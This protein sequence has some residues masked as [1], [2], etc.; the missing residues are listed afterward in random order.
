MVCI[1]SNA[2]RCGV[3][4]FVWRCMWSLLD[5]QLYMTSVTGFLSFRPMTSGPED[6]IVRQ[7]GGTD[8]RIEVR[9]DEHADR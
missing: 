1:R 8:I 3:V 7:N 2:K 5:S 6:D 9:M 4:L